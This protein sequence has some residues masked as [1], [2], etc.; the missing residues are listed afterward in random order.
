MLVAGLTARRPEAATK[1][2]SDSPDPR[3]LARYH[4]WKDMLAGFAPSKDWL[5]VHRIS[6]WMGIAV[7]LMVSANARA[8]WM[9]VV[10]ILFGWLVA[11]GVRQMGDRKVD[12]RHVYSGVSIPAVYGAKTPIWVKLVVTIIPILL[13]VVLAFAMMV[14]YAPASTMIGLPLLVF[15]LLAWKLCKNAQAAYWRDLVKYQQLLDKWTATGDLQKAW[16]GVWLTQVSKIGADGNKM[17]ILRCRFENKPDDSMIEPGMETLHRSNAQVFKLGVEPVR[18][19]TS[20]S[21]YSFAM[22]LPAR[23]KKKGEFAFDPSS[24]RLVLGRDESCVPEATSRQA[25]E[26][27]A[28]LVADIAYARTAQV[29][30]KR[31][32]LVEAHDVSDDP[33][34]AA[35]LLQLHCPPEGGDPID[36]MDFDW[37]GPECSPEETMK[38]PMFADLS[39]AFVLAAD[40]NTPLSDKGNKWRPD[41][42][43]LK[44]PF[45]DYIAISRRYKAEQSVWADILPTKL[46]VPVAIYDGEKTVECDGWELTTLP[47]ILSAPAT[48]DDYARFDLSPL[49]YEAK[50]IGVIRDGEN[51]LL[52]TATGPAPSRLDRLT[53]QYRK[54]AEAIIFKALLDVLP[55]K[56]IVYIDSCTQ[57]GKDVAIWRV[58]FH[59]E[60]GATVADVRKKSANLQAA[61]GANRIFWNWKNADS[62]EIWLC[63]QPYLALDDL[64]HWKRRFAQKELIQLALSDAWGVAGITDDSGRTPQVVSLGVLPQNHDV[65]LA[66]FQIP[67]GLDVDK[68]ERNIGKFMT[69]ANYGYGRI[70]P[71]GEEHGA[72]MYDMVLAKHSPFPTKILADWDYAK[73]AKPRMFPIGVDDMGEPVCWNVKETFH[74]LLCGKSGTGKS[75]L[76]QIVVAEALMKGHAIILVDPSKGCIDF[77]QWAK[78]LSLA[79]IGLGQ[80]RETEAVIAWLRN[81]M[82]ERVKLFS[83]Y[84]VG[85]IYDL[86]TSRLSEDELKHVQPID[87]IFDEFNSYLQEAGK[88]TQNPNRDIQ[89]AN[90]NAAVSAINNSIRRTMSALGKIVVQGRTAGISVILGAQR[91]TMDDMKPYNATAF[92][93]S[94]G[95]VLLGMDSPAGVVSQQ[96]LHEANR[97]QQSLKGEGGKIP[98]GR[99][100]FET[101]QGE[102]L[103]VQTWYSGGQEKLAELFKDN[104]PPEPIDYSMFMP[105]EAE[106]YG[107][108]SEEELSKLINQD[109]DSASGGEEINDLAELQDMLSQSEQTEPY[110]NGDEDDPYADVEEVD[111]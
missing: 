10:N 82:A 98:Q 27:L 9:T 104:T 91:L 87:L 32:P 28:S 33:E 34:Q 65:L 53:G 103:A 16:E 81:E 57:E 101:A 31:S 23:Q 12:R 39:D 47:L 102:L 80:M 55:A 40:P 88:T 56:A 95:R 21:G 76:A 71:R 45:A 42:V 25:G 73:Q 60:G 75:S 85:S 84:G 5:S 109:K 74:L 36:K 77:T 106:K 63:D 105:A 29:W 20:P 41:G 69:S 110:E 108:M 24:V 26:K 50:F 67:A 96:N 61:V 90:D 37:L 62:A 79:F 107:E 64:K 92:F 17:I 86:D 30:N 43:T 100:I 94:L 13:L 46:G 11:M 51:A 111:W 99:G 49:D 66:R 4:K 58:K 7:G 3:A 19:V 6:W 48:A 14:G 38:L 70:L 22:L 54:Y 78:R 68:P 44:K 89:L 8:G 52:V 1:R 72:T 2:K 18:A 59:L 35:W 15:L 83:R 93:R 97:L